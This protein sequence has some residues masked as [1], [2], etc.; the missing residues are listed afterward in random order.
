[1]NGIAEQYSKM[2][3]ETTELADFFLDPKAWNFALTIICEILRALL[4]AGELS[5]AHLMMKNVFLVSEIE[6]P[7]EMDKQSGSR[8]FQIEQFTALLREILER[9]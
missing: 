6:L 3:E 5:A 8:R 7:L 2:V 1:M 9:E 4:Q